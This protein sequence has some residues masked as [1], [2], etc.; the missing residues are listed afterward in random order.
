MNKPLIF[1][2]VTLPLLF[3]LML[4]KR[5]PQ[6]QVTQ[7]ERPFRITGQGIPDATK[8]GN[9][10]AA[11]EQ[12]RQLMAY[13]K[14]HPGKFN[15]IEMGT[16]A[17]LLFL[18]DA[19]YAEDEFMRTMKSTSFAVPS[20]EPDIFFF[21]NVY[22]RMNRGY[23]KG[24]RSKGNATGF[25]IVGYRNGE[26]KQIPVSQVRT[27]RHTTRAYCFPGQA[28]SPIRCPTSSTPT[29]ANRINLR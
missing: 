22:A 15:P 29:T 28:N 19:K 13:F 20:D 11:M 25:F 17:G 8:V 21:S 3:A 16:D 24:D 23:Y 26:V 12:S 9:V 18:P 7:P 14:A 1:A 2:S 6:A 10:E 5:N 27:P 4:S